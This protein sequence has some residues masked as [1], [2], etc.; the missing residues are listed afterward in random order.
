MFLFIYVCLIMHIFHIFWNEQQSTICCFLMGKSSSSKAPSTPVATRAHLLDTF[1]MCNEKV[2][3]INDKR[4]FFHIHNKLTI[5][6]NV[7]FAFWTHLISDGLFYFSAEVALA[8]KDA[9]NRKSPLCIIAHFNIMEYIEQYK[10]I[11]N[12]R[13]CPLFE[14]IVDPFKSRNLFS[15][16]SKCQFGLDGG[17]TVSLKSVNYI[18]LFLQ[19]SLRKFEFSLT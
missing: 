7:L 6:W 19:I 16:I 17:K 4:I 1:Q 14:S 13:E 18:L 10:I 3:V 15:G 9:F 2:S 8:Q 5:Y 11:T 12:A